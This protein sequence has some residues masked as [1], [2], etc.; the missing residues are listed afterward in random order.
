MQQV[1]PCNLTQFP[2]KYLGL[3]LAVRKLPKTVFYTLIDA[4]AERL[5]GWKASLIHPVG[6][7]TLVK[8]VLSSIPIY[9]QITIHCPKWVIK[10][11]LKKS[12]M[13]PMERTHGHKRGHC[14]VGWQ[15]VC[16]APEIGGLGVHNLEVMGWSLHMR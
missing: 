4:I 13:V 3:P 12:A 6:R 15:C 1:F 5:P 10:A 16:H 8:V 14:L 11:I 9:F 7:A 2:C